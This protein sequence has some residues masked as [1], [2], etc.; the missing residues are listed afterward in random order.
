M[1]DRR[2]AYGLTVTSQCNKL[3][4]VYCI[5]REAGA[6][7]ARACKHAA[8]WRCHY[9]VTKGTRAQYI[10]HIYNQTSLPDP[11]AEA[12][13]L[14]HSYSNARLASIYLSMCTACTCTHQVAF[15]DALLL[16]L[17]TPGKSCNAANAGSRMADDPQVTQP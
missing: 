1:Y 3:K 5:S 10:V 7:L 6:A 13:Y 4:Y 15:L 8:N 11:F 2:P 12:I 17:L 14:E 9:L 16:G